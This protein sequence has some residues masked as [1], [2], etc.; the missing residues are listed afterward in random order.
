[1][2]NLLREL[3][4]EILI[5]ERRSKKN[6]PPRELK[7]NIILNCRVKDSCSKK[8]KR[9]IKKDCKNKK[10]VQVKL[11]VPDGRGDFSIIEFDKKKYMVKTNSLKVR[12]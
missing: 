7:A 11:K 2:N 8:F 9:K 10:T 3:I 6:K 12:K 1:M 5:L 4:F